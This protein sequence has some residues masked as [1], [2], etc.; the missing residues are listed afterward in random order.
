VEKTKT[1]AGHSSRRL[2]AAGGGEEG[3]TGDLKRVRAG[4][5]EM[6]VQI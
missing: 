1:D 4:R 3:M 2:E 6:Q 5:N